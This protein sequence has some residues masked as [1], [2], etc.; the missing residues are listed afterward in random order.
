MEYGLYN[1]KIVKTILEKKLDLEEETEPPV[2]T[3]LPE[4]ENIRGESY[5]N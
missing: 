5:F 3:L 1:Y 2:R 4:H